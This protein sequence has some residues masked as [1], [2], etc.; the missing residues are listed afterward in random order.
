MQN[1]TPPAEVLDP[2]LDP[3]H[4][5]PGILTVIHTD[6]TRTSHTVL[7]VHVAGS[8]PEPATVECGLHCQGPS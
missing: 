6:G 4:S 7:Y 2:S 8:T 5:S 1:R 3:M